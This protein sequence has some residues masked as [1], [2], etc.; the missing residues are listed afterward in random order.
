MARL[1]RLNGLGFFLI[2]VLTLQVSQIVH[3]SHL[4]L[5]VSRLICLLVSGGAPRRRGCDGS[6]YLTVSWL[7]AAVFVIDDIWMIS[8][9]FQSQKYGGTLPLAALRKRGAIQCKQIQK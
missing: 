3:Y 2:K 5:R 6:R 8:Q 1:L 9:H 4:I 7:S